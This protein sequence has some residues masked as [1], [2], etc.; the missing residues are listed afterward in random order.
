MGAWLFVSVY[1]RISDSRDS[2]SK[3]DRL[4]GYLDA[5]CSRRD[6]AGTLVSK[7]CSGALCPPVG[8]NRDTTNDFPRIAVA[9]SGPDKG[10]VYVT[11][12]DCRIANGGTQEEFPGLGDFDT[13]I[14]LAFSDDQGETWSEPVLVAGEG[15]GKIQFWPTVSIQPGGNVDITYYESEEK[16]LDPDEDEECIVPLG[17]RWKSSLSYLRGKF[18][19]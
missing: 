14:Y 15:D 18:S 10:R 17:A 6:P 2:C 16:N 12:Q 1:R 8:Y 19:G 7:I 13:D 5:R 9:Q 4:W 11:W 3:V